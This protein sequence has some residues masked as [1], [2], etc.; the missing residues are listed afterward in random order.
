MID[1]AF[2][3]D[4][5]EHHELQNF[6]LR[7][8]NARIIPA[9]ANSPKNE[10]YQCDETTHHW[11]ETL[12]WKVAG[13]KEQFIA[14]ALA[15]GY[16][17]LF[18]VDS[19][20]YLHPETLRHLISLEKDIVSEVFWTKWAPD[21]QALPQVWLSGQYKLYSEPRGEAL[22]EAAANQATLEFLK[23]LSR[24][25]TYKVGG[26]GACTLISAKALSAGVSFQEIYNLDLIG[27]DRHF[28]VRAAALG[29]ELFADTHYPP[30]HIYRKSELA[31]LKQYKKNLK[32]TF[33]VSESLHL[34]STVDKLKDNGADN[35][36]YSNLSAYNSS[37]RDSESGCTAGITLGML[38]R[39]EAGRYLYDV[40]DHAAQYVSKA[41][42]LDDASEDESA[43]I[44][45]SVFARYNIPLTLVRNKEAGFHNEILLR[46]QLWQLLI[47]TH[48]SW[49]LCLDA[50]EIFEASAPPALKALAQRADVDYFA[51]RLY[52][53]W[54]STHYRDDTHWM[55]HHYYRPLLI[56]Y[57]SDFD[58]V[59]QE[60][61]QHCGR[62]PLNI[63]EQKGEMNPLRVKHLGWA[64]PRE[65]L[66]KYFR[67]K[68]LDP[69][70]KY[71]IAAQ[72]ESILDPCPNLIPWQD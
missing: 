68:R 26:L 11:Q 31:G 56:R 1:Y 21:L 10:T 40:L 57:R 52:D 60:T 2:I 25:G 53:M 16:D 14:L 48:P 13:F 65:R 41:V 42:I 3:D 17:Y 50:D 15:E 20:L 67:Y 35:I 12:I 5:N 59:W 19:D 33:N 54:S 49:I 45:R 37:T 7:Y 30:Y 66:A 18:L 27:E 63:L 32:K 4:H 46:K 61:P 8:P 70:A 22:N 6:S 28:C 29:F 51:F 39:N 36:P 72:Y 55:A 69:D 62:Y 23:Q 38:I 34:S 44:C 58:Y 9:Q 64:N 71:G 47:S 24:P 43:E